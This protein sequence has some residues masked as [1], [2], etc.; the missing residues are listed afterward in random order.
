[1]VLVLLGTLAYQSSL[2]VYTPN[3]HGDSNSYRV[4]RRLS[5]GSDISWAICSTDLVQQHLFPYSAW[6][7]DYEQAVAS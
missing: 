1:M 4:R 3:A 5:Q 2:A 7:L 6:S